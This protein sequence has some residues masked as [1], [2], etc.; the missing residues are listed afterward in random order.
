MKS[1]MKYVWLLIVLIILGSVIFWRIKSRTDPVDAKRQ[2]SVQ[3]KADLPKSD[4]IVYTLNYTGD[5]ASM[6][7]ANIYAKVTGNIEK[8]FV[9]IG[10]SVKEGQLL[11]LIDTTELSQSYMQSLATFENARLTYNRVSGLFDQKLA[12]KQD[13][14]NS[15]TAFDIAKANFESTKLRLSYAWICAPFSGV[16]TKRYFDQGAMVTSTNTILFNLMDANSMKLTIELLEKDIALVKSGM[17]VTISVDAF[18]GKK[19]SGIVSRFSE[20]IDPA[21]R[22]MDTEIR[23][24]NVGRELKPGMFARAAI[25]V[26]RHE[27]ALTIPTQAIAKNESGA[28]IF[29][30][31]NGIAKRVKIEVGKEQGTISEVT[32]GIDAEDSVITV[33]MQSVRDGGKVNVQK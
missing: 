27:N 9:N 26:D 19:Y 33:G 30:V 8:I 21:T 12:S 32:K 23:V 10:E 13:F 18:P 5:V 22:T 15:K 1:K 20:A 29:T 17:P 6:Q 25:V 24:P 31:S 11:A 28:T 14:D 7:Q 16:I 3:V 2:N 4:T